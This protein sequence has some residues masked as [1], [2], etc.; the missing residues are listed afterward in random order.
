METTH[1][2]EPTEAVESSEFSASPSLDADFS[3]EHA[4]WLRHYE[5]KVPATIPYR[6][7]ALGEWLDEAAKEAP[8]S[9]A[10]RFFNTTISFAQLNKLAEIT[11]A[12]LRAFGVKPGDRV[13]VM[14]PNIPQTMVVFWGDHWPGIARWPRCRMPAA[15]G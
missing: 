8:R 9:P 2:S 5:P 7:I 12:N 4:L 15:I 13:G 10:C 6:N 11:A 14:L 3:L 1:F